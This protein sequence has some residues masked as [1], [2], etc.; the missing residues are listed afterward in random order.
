M[1]KDLTGD[2]KPEPKPEIVTGTVELIV[3]PEMREKIELKRLKRQ[4]M[5]V[6]GEELPTAERSEIDLGDLDA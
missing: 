5:R 4:K 3:T 2:S 1:P 6:L